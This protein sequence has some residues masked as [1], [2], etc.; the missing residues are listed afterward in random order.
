[1]EN[2]DI[3][4]VHEDFDNVVGYSPPVQQIKHNFDYEFL[5]TPD[6]GYVQCNVVEIDTEKQL[7]LVEFNHPHSAGWRENCQGGIYTDVVEMWRVR[8]KYV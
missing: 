4:K 1:M 7:I 6:I 8:R 5:A 2:K 3:V